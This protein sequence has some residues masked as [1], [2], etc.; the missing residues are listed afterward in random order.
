MKKTIT[1]ILVANVLML[2]RMRERVYS[3]P[4]PRCRA[5]ITEGTI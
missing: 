4:L 5:Y 3:S 1:T 2:F